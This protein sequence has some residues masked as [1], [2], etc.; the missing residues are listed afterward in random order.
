VP[1]IVNGEVKAARPAM[2]G[3]KR[4]YRYFPNF[5]RLAVFHQMKLA[6][7]RG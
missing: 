5:K 2:H 1:P 7:Q 3:P 4:G 6:P